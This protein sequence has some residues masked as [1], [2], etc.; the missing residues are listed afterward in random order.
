VCSRLKDSLLRFKDKGGVVY[1]Q[2]NGFQL[3]VK[4]GLLPGIDDDFSKQTLTL[5]HNDCGSY[6]VDF[7][8]HRIEQTNH[9]AFQGLRNIYL[10]CRHGEGKLIFYSPNGTISKQQSE[11]NRTK[12]NQDHVL[13]R[14][15]NPTTNSPTGEFPFNPNSS[16]DAIA[17]LYNGTF[18]GHMAHTEV[19]VYQSR[20]PRWFEIKDRLRRQGIKAKDL[21]EK[22][23][24]GEA[25]QVFRNIVNHFK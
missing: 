21:D 6:R 16:V 18:F 7:V 22:M 3:M 24:E 17:G 13:L 20:D 19:G 15:V 14:Y 1:S 23:L 8:L 5:T 25:L 11:E 4:T 10:W 2:C 12:V 9:F